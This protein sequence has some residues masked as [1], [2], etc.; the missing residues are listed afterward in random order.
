MEE[1]K[2]QHS[3]YGFMQ[4]MIYFTIIVEYSLFVYFDAPFWKGFKVVLIKIH[5]LPIYYNILNSKLSTFV[6]I[7]LV[8]IGTVARKDLHLN[9]KTQIVYPLAGGLLLFFGSMYFAGKPSSVVFKY[10]TVNDI[11]YMTMS[12]IGAVMTATSMD[13]ISKLIKSGL[14]KD[15]WNVEG[16]SFMQ[17]TKAD[18]T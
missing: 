8:S 18:I 13:N 16:E 6:L 7:C 15:K 11:L 17:H 2:E 3:L 1:S 5:N 14:G 10:T 4:A 12:F 9:P